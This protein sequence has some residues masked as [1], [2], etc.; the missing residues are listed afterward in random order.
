MLE[1]LVT[2][3]YWSNNYK[4]IILDYDN[5][6]IIVL[7]CVLETFTLIQPKIPLP[8]FHFPTLIILDLTIFH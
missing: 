8:D 4:V 6:I 7:A 2:L 5:I 1:N 3:M